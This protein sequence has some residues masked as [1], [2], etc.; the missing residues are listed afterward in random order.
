[1]ANMNSPTLC[2][3]SWIQ[4]CT[5]TWRSFQWFSPYRNYMLKVFQRRSLQRKQ[6]I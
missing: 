1:M 2:S 4:T 5:S 6:I 3:A